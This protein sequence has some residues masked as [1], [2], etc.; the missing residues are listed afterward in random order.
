MK[1]THSLGGLK[2]IEDSYIGKRVF[3]ASLT[4]IAVDKEISLATQ[5][6]DLRI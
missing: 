3:F 5:P 2:E 6:E 4:T 1:S